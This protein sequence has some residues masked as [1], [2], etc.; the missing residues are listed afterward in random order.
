VG[1]EYLENLRQEAQTARQRFDYG[2]DET[3]LAYLKKLAGKPD[4]K[5]IGEIGFNCGCSSYAFL[6]ASPENLVYSFDLAEFSYVEA[7]KQHIDDTFPGRHLLIRGNSVQ[8]V[9]EFHLGNSQMKFDLIFID[10]C[11]DFEFVRADLLNMRKMAT[12]NTILV[13]DDITPWKPWCGVGTTL[14]WLEA[15]WLGKVVQL[16]YV[17]EGREGAPMAPPGNRAWVVGRYNF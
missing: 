13:I 17:K 7:A 10:G 15:L 9:P 12:Q 3:E 4:V 2:A 8:T 14:A 5:V 16:T 1:I 6:E 11:H